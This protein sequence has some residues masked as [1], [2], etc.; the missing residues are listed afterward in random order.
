M[1]D[2]LGDEICIQTTED[3]VLNNSHLLRRS[4]YQYYKVYSSITTHDA[5]TGLFLSADVSSIIDAIK[6]HKHYPERQLSYFKGNLS[7]Q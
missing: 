2:D 5:A 1:S 6:P 7:S 4:L 3:I